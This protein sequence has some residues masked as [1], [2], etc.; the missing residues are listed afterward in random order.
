MVSN[1]CSEV[2][3]E[4]Q[5]DRRGQALVEFAVVSFALTFL[6]GAMLAFGFLF[7]SANVLQQAADVGAMEFAR[8]PAPPDE[9]FQNAL[10]ASELYS[11]ADLV[12]PVGT[13]SDELPL[14]NGLLFSVYVYDP[15]IDML[16][17][18]GTLV[19]N[20][21]GETT[22]VIPIVGP[23]NRDA[24]T[25]VETITEWRR[26]VEEVIPAG[27][28]AG[29]Y[30]MMATLDEQGGLGQPGMVALR[31]N[32]P[33]QS[34]ALVAYVHT[35]ADGN[36]L[37]PPETIGRDDVLNVPVTADDDA[38]TGATTATFPDGD[39][40]SDAGY[41]LVDPAA[42]SDIGDLSA[43]GV[44]VIVR[45][46]S[47][48]VSNARRHP[49]RGTILTWFAVFL[50]ALLPLMSLIVHL[51][52]VTLARR[53]MQTAVNT[54]A[55]EGVRF[56]DDVDLL[57]AE[58]RSQVRDLVS[59]V[60]DDDLN[61][62]DGLDAMQFGA[63]SVIAFDDE[64]TDISLPGT[65]FRA[66]R[67]ISQ[68]NIGVYDPEL[69]LNESNERH[70][71]MVRGDYVLGTDHGEEDSYQRDDFAP[72][73]DGDAF[74]VRLRRV[75]DSNSLDS[76]P[77]V[78]SSGPTIPFLFGRGPYGG[79]EFLDRRERGTIVR[80]TAIARAVPAMTVGW[81]SDEVEV[82]AATVWVEMQ[83]WND[84]SVGTPAVVTLAG[85]TISGSLTGEF[86]ERE[87]GVVAV[88]DVLSP[89]DD[90]PDPVVGVRYLPVYAEI[91]GTKRV[92]GF[93]VADLTLDPNNMTGS[94]TMLESQVGRLNASATW[95]G[96]LA[97]MSTADVDDLMEARATLEAPLL[98]PALSRT[99]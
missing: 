8:H 43:G 35:D 16:R 85:T 51:G 7:F 64:P 75:D 61:D 98:A 93:G 21:E 3:L 40:L 39:T 84:L 48:V 77:Y 14:I 31:I 29:P 91:S 87:P 47:E 80:A 59:A 5:G 96:N 44:R 60:Y 41:S 46:G 81:S 97:G 20:G 55:L 88:G 66:S 57:E 18:P 82:G 62:P 30:S 86:V 63:G 94:I 10:A 73:V 50:F 1:W 19:T 28:T 99:M 27:E 71:D 54:A 45:R 65:D 37:S 89:P 78:S 58:R 68:S 70:G 74:L 22:V 17:Y 25:G 90:T 49:R 32:Y 56:R 33:Y 76:D 69:E 23:G 42:D 83:S 2:R 15:D 38:V 72:N 24:T 53:Q 92:V 79:S 67:T 4:R 36:L 52:M 95:R 26:V 12:V 11:E 13:R 34:S 9:T 6:L